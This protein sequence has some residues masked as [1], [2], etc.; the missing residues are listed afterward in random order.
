M[1]LKRGFQALQGGENGLVGV[2]SC[3]E[4]SASLIWERKKSFEV[5]SVS[6]MGQKEFKACERE[7]L[8]LSGAR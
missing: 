5:G 2:M 8:S 1:C 6:K 3:Q 4:L 7:G